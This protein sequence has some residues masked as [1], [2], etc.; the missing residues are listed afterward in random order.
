MGATLDALHQLQN[1]ETRLRSLREQIESKRRAVE[2]RKRRLATL[3]RETADTH[4]QIRKAQAEAD[5]LELQRKTHEGHIAKLRE[6]LNQA[7]TNKEYA[8]LLTQ[9]NTDKANATKVEDQV[10]AALTR[11]D[12]LKKGEQENR[13]KLQV[14]R[15]RLSEMEKQAADLE[16]SLADQLRSLQ[17]QREAATDGVP[18]QI[19]QL[20][21]RA[22]EKHDGEAMAVIERTHPKRGEY[23]CSGCNMSLTL[24][25]INALQS[26]G[27]E[28]RIC[29][30]C[31]RILYLDAP[32]GAVAR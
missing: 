15:E 29:Q 18:P 6:A 12:E 17:A 25:T 20:F 19:L 14:E 7:K 4:E 22:C 21:E 32:A 5:R 13:A 28:V 31:S 10:L 16:A 30:T 3:E 27:D 1:I 2:A 8:A 24:E 26:N 11:V 9:L 23:T